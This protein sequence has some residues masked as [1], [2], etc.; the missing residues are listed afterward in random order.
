MQRSRA[1]WALLIS[2]A[3]TGVA[4]LTLPAVARDSIPESLRLEE[5]AKKN[6]EQQPV[7]PIERGNA[8][9]RDVGGSGGDTLPSD[10]PALAPSTPSTTPPPASTSSTP[11]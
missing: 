4:C 11:K 7:V 9:H 1:T 3:A 10:D 8:H 5:Q 2:A 6:Y